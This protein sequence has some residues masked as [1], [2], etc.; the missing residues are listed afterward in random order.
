MERDGAIVTLFYFYWSLRLCWGSEVGWSKLEEDNA[1]GTHY[2]MF[3]FRK[4]EKDAKGAQ[5]VSENK[6]S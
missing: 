5:D 4:L 1:F 2:H 3:Y 6:I